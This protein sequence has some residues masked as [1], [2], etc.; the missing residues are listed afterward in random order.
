MSNQVHPA[1][2]EPPKSIFDQL[3]LSKPES[4]KFPK[5]IYEE[6]ERQAKNPVRKPAAA[7][8]QQQQQQPDQQEDKSKPQSPKKQQPKKDEVIMMDLQE[9][10]N[11]YGHK[12][13]IQ[14][15]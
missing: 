11:A 5:P 14:I 10:S 4:A 15:R 13:I 7:R 6:T 2:D 3:K 9:C 1:G 12:L 8:Q